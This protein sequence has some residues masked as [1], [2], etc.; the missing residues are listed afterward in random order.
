MEKFFV[1]YI[2]F[3]LL[4][5]SR[6]GKMPVTIPKEVEVKLINGVLGVKGKKGELSY[7]FTRHASIAVTETEIVIASLSEEKEDRALH[8]LTRALIQ[9]MVVGV[10]DGFEKRLEIIGVG[11]RAQATGKKISL[12]L[13][14]SHPVDMNAP[15][16]IVVEVDKETKHVVISG[17]DKQ[18]VGQFASEI[19]ALRKPEPYKGKGVRY[20]G[21]YVARKAGKAASK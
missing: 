3:S 5:M 19:R 15:E 13:G 2:N 21:E 4:E 1:K 6:I 7:D 16:G 20:V 14:F 11:Y 9:N 10:S 12:S 17:I 18:K 8:G